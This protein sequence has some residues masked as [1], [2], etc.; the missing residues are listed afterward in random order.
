MTPCPFRLLSLES[1]GRR[2]QRVFSEEVFLCLTWFPPLRPKASPCV[3]VGVNLLSEGSQKA[4]SWRRPFPLAV[5]PAV[6][7]IQ[8]G[9]EVGD[10]VR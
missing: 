1:V 7:S 9:L 5:C 3:C 8:R 6:Q 10:I 4:Q 2:S